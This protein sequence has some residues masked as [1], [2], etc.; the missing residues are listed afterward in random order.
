MASLGAIAGGE[1]ATQVYDVIHELQLNALRGRGFGGRLLGDLNFLTVASAL[2][3]ILFYG[4]LLV[5][6][7]ALVALIAQ[8]RLGRTAA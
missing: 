8:R 4:M 3:N 2:R 1:I 7:T 6:L 5:G